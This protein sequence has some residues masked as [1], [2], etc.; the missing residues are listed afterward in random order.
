MLGPSPL[1]CQDASRGM[2]SWGIWGTGMDPKPPHFAVKHT[3]GRLSQKKGSAALEALGHPQSALSLLHRFSVIHT[4]TR[5]D[6]R[7]KGSFI[8]GLILCAL[9]ESTPLSPLRQPHSWLPK[10][11]SSIPKILIYPITVVL[12]YNLHN[13]SN[14]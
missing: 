7:S 4:V 6:P 10:L 9:L 11:P 3:R 14:V 5:K 2:F 13:K 8:D 1:K 12:Y